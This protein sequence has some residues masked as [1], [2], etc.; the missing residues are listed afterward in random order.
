M[1]NKH[2]TKSKFDTNYTFI[3]KQ[4]F[5]S[6][7][8]LVDNKSGQGFGDNVTD[9][10]VIFCRNGPYLSDLFLFF[11]LIDYRQINIGTQ[12]FDNPPGNRNLIRANGYKV[13]LQKFWHLYPTIEI[14]VISSQDMIREAL[15]A[16]RVGAS[17]YLTYPLNPDEVNMSL[18]APMT[19]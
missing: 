17:N 18:K 16:V 14:I 4:A 12:D 7:A 11:S 8:K 6:P 10:R 2:T 9:G 15:M 3:T 1:S 13:A 5:E 19:P